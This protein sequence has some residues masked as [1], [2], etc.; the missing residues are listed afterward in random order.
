MTRPTATQNDGEEH[1]VA[2]S[3]ALLT[4]SPLGS[5]DGRGAGVGVHIDVVDV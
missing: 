1:D 4:A 2:Y 5:E 3:V